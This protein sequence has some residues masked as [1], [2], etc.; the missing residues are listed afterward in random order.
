VI[1]PI[2][3]L[4]IF[5]TLS[6]VAV[7]G[8]MIGYAFGRLERKLKFK[9]VQTDFGFCIVTDNTLTKEQRNAMK[10]AWELLNNKK[11]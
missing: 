10:V 2:I 7:I 4:T 11:V 9:I 6:V 5:T 3:A 8:M 1:T